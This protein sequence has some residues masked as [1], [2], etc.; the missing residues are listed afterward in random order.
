[1]GAVDIPVTNPHFSAEAQV[2]D[3]SKTDES[4]NTSGTTVHVENG[5]TLQ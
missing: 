3:N 1:M 2:T 4:I 5:G